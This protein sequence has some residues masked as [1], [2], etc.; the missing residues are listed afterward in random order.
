MSLKLCLY[1]D[2]NGR[3][4]IC[5][6]SGHFVQTIGIAMPLPDHLVPVVR[7]I[8]ATSI[9]DPPSPWRCIGSFSVG[10]LTDVG[11]GTRSDLLMVIS[12][13]GRGV[14]DCLTGEKVARDY[15]DGD[16]HDTLALEAE[17]IGPLAEQRIKTAGLHGGGLPMAAGD[18]WT[19]EDFVLDWPDHTLLLVPPG[20]WAY[21]DGF[22]K[23]ANYTKV[24]V[25]SELRAWG[26]SPTGRCL[27]LATSSDLTCWNRHL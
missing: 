17:G 23:P 12:S 8:R 18:G 13:M 1:F 25:E 4:S 24:A 19:A 16:W 7:R 6:V 10:G 27:I 14:F 22:G 26:F 15:D 5:Q 3:N 21:G 9:S 11:F 2:E 20:S